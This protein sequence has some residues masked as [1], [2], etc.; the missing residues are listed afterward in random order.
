M[1]S[2]KTIRLNL[3]AGWRPI[4]GYTNHDIVKLKGIDIT[5]DLNIFP[6]PYKD[7]SV[8][9]V[10]MHD[11]LEHLDNVVQVMREVHRILKPGGF[12]N[13]LVPHWNSNGPYYDPT[14]KHAFGFT[15]FEYFCK[16]YKPEFHYYFDFQFSKLRR[17]IHFP[18][19]LQIWNRVIEFLVNLSPCLSMIY[20][21]TPL[22][23]FPSEGIE[24]WLTK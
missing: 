1:K 23:I 21:T 14:H 8:D 7:N 5:F 11:V 6:W 16:G 19:G 20:E 10:R 18:G 17:H 12:V 22:K 4:P 2:S 15:T 9:E 3:G 13:L 24:I